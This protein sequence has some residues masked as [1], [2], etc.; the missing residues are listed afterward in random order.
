MRRRSVHNTT[1]RKS[2]G[3]NIVTDNQKILLDLIL[4]NK[5]ESSFFQDN[6][7][8][9]LN[10][11]TN[12]SNISYSEEGIKFGAFVELSD[13]DTDKKMK[14][15]LVGDFEADINK[16]INCQTVYVQRLLKN[17]VMLFDLYRIQ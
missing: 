1:R 15:R 5:K 11:I 12:N 2:Q 17:T 4:K 9:S 3:N 13:I 10:N 7:S 16:E 6:N 14:I 8:D